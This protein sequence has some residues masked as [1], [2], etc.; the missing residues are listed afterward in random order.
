MKRLI[1]GVGINDSKST[2]IEG[3]RCKYY[4]TWKSMLQRCYSLKYKNK[5]PTYANCSVCDEWLTFSNF[6]AWM[7]KQNWEGKD[8]DKDILIEGNKIYSPET[9]FFISRRINTLLNVSKKR[10]GSLPLGV[11]FNKKN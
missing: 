5:N 7:V 1:Y 4:V 9:C 3:K 11:T 2:Y 8:L 6:K 10:I